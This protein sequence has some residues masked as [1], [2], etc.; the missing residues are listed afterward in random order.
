MKIV[1]AGNPNCGKT[2]I[3]NL[4]TGANNAVGNYSGVTVEVIEGSFSRNNTDYKLVDLPGIYSLS[5]LSKDEIVARDY[6]LENKPDLIVNVVDSSNL[7]RNLFLSLQL[8]ELGIPLILVLNMIDLAHKKGYYIDAKL[9]AEHLGVHVVEIDSSKREGADEVL[10]ALEEAFVNLDSFAP[11]QGT[12]LNFSQ[13]I[14]EELSNL[15]QEILQSLNNFDFSSLQADKECNPLSPFWLLTGESRKGQTTSLIPREKANLES[16]AFK[17]RLRWLTVKLLENDRDAVQAWKSHVKISSDSGEIK[18]LEVLGKSPLVSQIASERYKAVQRICEGVITKDV[19]VGKRSRFTD[20][21]DAILTHPFWGL[22]IFFV[23]MYGVFWLTFTL[24]EV[25]VGWLE[26]FQSFLSKT[27]KDF[28]SDNPDSVLCSLI[29]DGIIS[30]VGGVLVFFP[31]I[32]ILFAAIAILEESGY[33]ARGAFLMDRYLSKVGL[34][35]KSF[36]P[37]LVGFGCSVPAVM[38]A[39]IIEDK[40]LRLITIFIVPLMS[41]GARFPIYMLIIPAFFPRVWQAPILWGIYVLGIVLALILAIILNRGVFKGNSAP[42]LIE[43]PTY[44]LP[45]LRTVGKRACERGIQYLHK[46]GSTILG[47]SVILWCIS[48]FP[49]LPTES[50]AEFDSRESEI[51]SLAQRLQIDLGEEDDLPSDWSEMDSTTASFPWNEK[52]TEEKVLKSAPNDPR[53]QQSFLLALLEKNQNERMEA[54]MENSVAGRLGRKIEPVLKLAGFDWRIGIGLIGAFAAKEVFVAQ[55]GVVFKSGEV[56]EESETLRSR[57]QRAYTPLIGLSVLVFCL[58]SAP[59]MATFVI[60]AKET[61][62]KWACG[63]W[64]VLTLL[65]FALSCAVFQGGRFFN[66][67]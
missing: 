25:P 13:A 42:L 39:R 59:C 21:I 44:H 57:I 7:E 19:K 27:V 8:I 67:G 30:G 52:I 20:K 46:A 65:G 29:V 4:L 53:E 45:T 64:C 9:L 58:V 38:A 3:F 51:R 26:Q 17:C 16:W 40:R 11:S 55:L 1:L 36:I 28:W 49:V 50:L 15:Q 63:Q 2:T 22:V 31:N 23:T 33:I 18:R 6:L 34:T 5:S 32:F 60:V 37:L 41:C 48:S 66:W 14:E 24:G 61:S 47:V 12:F 43:L 35:G 62:L 10:R 54:Q 56:D